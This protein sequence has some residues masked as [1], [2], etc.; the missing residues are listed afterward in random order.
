MYTVYVLYS[1]PHNQIYIGY[2]SNLIQRI[3]NH[4]FGSTESH[5]KKFRPWKV[6]Y[7]DFLQTKSEALIREKQLK[8]FQG[9]KFIREVQIPLMNEIGFL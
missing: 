4:N 8:S 5:T 3:W 9:R 6:I 2:T 1:E 7:T